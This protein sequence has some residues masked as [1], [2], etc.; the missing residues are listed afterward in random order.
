MPK[1][2]HD[3]NI[4]ERG[5]LA[6]RRWPWLVAVAVLLVALAVAAGIWRG[7]GREAAGAA[8]PPE[9]T[10]TTATVPSAGSIVGPVA[11][12]DLTRDYAGKVIV[13]NYMASWCTACQVE[14]PSLVKA[15]D[16]YRDRGVQLVGIALQTSQPG[17]LT[18]IRRLGIDYPVYLDTSGAAAQQRFHL[19]GMPTTLVFR[20]GRLLKRFDGEVSGSQLEAFLA[21]V[22]G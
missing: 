13:V 2:S 5:R 9:A 15:Y 22:T 4:R 16:R 12:L 11:V 19:L 6:R 17:T 8:P 21:T 20:N 10:S 1:T 18:M 14:I 3:G 7:S